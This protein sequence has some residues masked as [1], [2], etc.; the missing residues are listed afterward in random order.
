MSIWEN[1]FQIDYVGFR[2]AIIV[3][4]MSLKKV[5]ETSTKV[6]NDVVPKSN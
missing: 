6:E 4:K 1:I 2:D 3:L 5:D